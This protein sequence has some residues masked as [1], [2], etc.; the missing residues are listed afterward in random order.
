MG[1]EDDAPGGSNRW[2]P[3]VAGEV[4]ADISGNVFRFYYSAWPLISSVELF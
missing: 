2:N 1:V 3:W 4:E